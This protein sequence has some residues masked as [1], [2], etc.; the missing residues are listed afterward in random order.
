MNQAAITR[1]HAVL[2]ILAMMLVIPHPASAHHG[3]ADFDP[4]AEVTLYGVV[5]DF[6]YVNPHSVVEFTVTDDK[7]Q[8]RLWQG[9]FGSPNELTRKGWTVTTLEAGAKITITGHPSKN[10]APALHVSSIVLATG[11]EMKLYGGR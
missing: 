4:M 10:G 2:A 3:W 11:K 8:V 6:H 5:M 7:G 9:E 1:C